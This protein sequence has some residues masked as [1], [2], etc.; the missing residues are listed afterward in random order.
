MLTILR[1]SMT[2]FGPFQGTQ[3]VEFSDQPGV[4]II[5]GE[6]GRGKTTLLNAIRFA[7]FGSV[8]TRAAQIV[9]PMDSINVEARQAGR[10]RTTVTLEFSHLGTSYALERRIGP[11][12]GVSIP[13]SASDLTTEF[14][15]KKGPDVVSPDSARAL[16]AAILPEA[17]S[18][19]FLFDGE[20][21]QEYEELLRNESTMGAEIKESIERILGLPVLTNAREDLRELH[22]ASQR[23]ETKAVTKD[24]KSQQLQTALKEA[25]ASRDHYQK[26]L[27]E[28]TTQR[29]ALESE[30]ASIVVEMQKTERLRALVEERRQL[31]Q[32]N[33]DLDLQLAE[34]HD[35]L[36]ELAASAWKAVLIDRIKTSQNEQQRRL[37]EL[38]SQQSARA[39]A[40]ASLRAIEEARRSGTCGMCGRSM[41]GAAHSHMEGA[42]AT[43][44]TAGEQPDRA[45][46][47]AAVKASL[48]ALNAVIGTAN[49]AVIAE[50][51]E[52]IDDL[53]L[54]M[55]RNRDRIAEIGEQTV[56]VAEPELVKLAQQDRSLTTQLTLLD[57]GIRSDQEKLAETA[58]RIEGI[59]KM[60]DKAGGTDLAK[61]RRQR[62][63]CAKMHKLFAGSV[64]TFR[65]RL[66]TRVQDAATAIFRELTNDPDYVGLQINANYGLQIVHRSGTLVPVRSAGNEHIV[67]LSLM[68]ALQRNAPMKGP[69]VMD[70]PFGRLDVLHKSNVVKNL[71]IIAEQVILLVYEGEVD[72]QQTR[73]A[74][75]GKLRREYRMKRISSFHTDI[76]PS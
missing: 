16:L 48:D 25:I 71:P 55:V 10:F 9:T 23:Q 20:L 68:A 28:K 57:Q 58:T 5:F 39:S 53:K 56:G 46:E 14:W 27:A 2:D 62:D 15:L 69:V 42:L 64:D 54:R 45:G 41:D 50:V 4:T 75:A 74:L 26:L 49:P 43:L 24:I 34:K 22:T 70:S 8:R 51:S 65:E 33:A 67:A 11:R 1:L 66:K 31:Q 47:I 19:F 72:A 73:N 12:P 76:V 21:L 60:L 18:R 35:R 37:E 63:L 36:R 32:T 3:S 40:I 13:K 7:L 59:E 61:E 44:K 29:Q 30:R 6:N 38:R 17:V 52:A